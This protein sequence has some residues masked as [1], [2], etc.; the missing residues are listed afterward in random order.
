MSKMIFH[1]AQQPIA[2]M[3][4]YM[5]LEWIAMISLVTSVPSAIAFN[6]GS[7]TI[8][9]N[10]A[11]IIKPQKTLTKMNRPFRSL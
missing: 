9:V 4:S 8:L 6:V 10:R 7:P 1:G 5:T 2:T 3:L 11:K